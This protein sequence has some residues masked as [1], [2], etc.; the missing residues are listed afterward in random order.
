MRLITLFTAILSLAVGTTV[1]WANP[2]RFTNQVFFAVLL[3]WAVWSGLVYQAIKAGVLLGRGE[4]ANPIPWLRANAAISTLMPWSLWLLKESV[5]S[6]DG[7]RV[8]TIRR[9]LPW[10]GLLLLGSL[11]YT[12]SFF[13]SKINVE[14][15]EKER[16]TGYFLFALGELAAFAWLVG[17]IYRQMRTLTGIRRLEMQ[18]LAFNIGVACLLGAAT[19]TVGNILHL[20][21]LRRASI[22]GLLA[23]NILTAWSITFHHVF[24]ARQLFRSLG[25]RLAMIAVLGLGIFGVSR[26]LEN[27]LSPLLSVLLSAASCGP[28]ALLLDRKSREWLDLGGERKLANI[29]RIIIEHARTGLSPDELVANFETLLREQFEASSAKLLFARSDVYA[30]GELE[31]TRQQPGFAALCEAGWATSESLQRRRSSPGFDDLRE[32]LVKHSLGIII[33]TPRGSTAPSLLVALGVKVNEWPFTYPEVPCLQNIAELMDN[34]LTH[35][36]LTIHAAQ[37]AKLEHLAM[38]SRGL[39]HDLKNLITPVSSF[40]I[41]TDNRFP[42]ESAEAEVHSAAKRSVRIMTDYVREALFFAERLS[43]RFERLD[44][45]RVFHHVQEQLAPSAK[46][47]GVGIALEITG[48]EPVTADAVLLQRLLANLVSNAIDASRPG[49]TIALSVRH[50]RPGW[51]RLE[52]VDHGCGIA[53]DNLARIFEPYFTTKEF[54]EDVRGF[55]LGLTICQKIVDLHRGTIAVW[56]EPGRGA[57]FTIDLPTAQPMLDTQAP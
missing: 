54:G 15:G 10:L 47:R 11:C 33:A 17:Q 46:R 56:S 18:L 13:L 8:R 9:S 34:I 23:T 5:A 19:S 28:L 7:E 2:R 45:G 21:V 37:Q 42:A 53:S 38:M 14:S 6:K 49:Q 27:F 32:F 4:N 39:A 25:Q 26:S 22:L 48:I 40:L 31:L 16:G 52:V 3:I 43:P 44:L 20:P 55:G 30:D 50:E 35:T 41:H 36:R 1:L 51:V 57:T 12:D 24:D 29:R